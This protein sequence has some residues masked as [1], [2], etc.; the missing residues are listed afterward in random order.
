MER[1]TLKLRTGDEMPLAGF[2]TWKIPND[3]C[4]E[5]VYQALKSGYKLLD[6][7]CD[8]GNEEKVGEGI[9]R[10]TDEG[11]VNRKDLWVTSKLWNTYHRREHVKQACL[12][13]LKD[14]QLDYLDLYLIHF[15]ISLKY[16]DPEVRYPPEWFFDP[17]A[18]KPRM[19]EDPVPIIETWRAMEE[20]MAEGL[21]KNIG[22]CNFNTSLLRDLLAAAKVKPSV[23]Q[24][25]LHPYLTQK[26]LIQ[27]CKLNEIQ[28]TTFSS[29]GGA[30][31][32]E[33][34][35]ANEDESLLNNEKVKEIATTH[36]KTAGQVLLRW[37]VQ[38]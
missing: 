28:M 32:V 31:Y 14:L 18:N 22:I 27:F 9:K 6:C 35:M 15:P 19:I 4:S 25:E 30:S 7:A 11:L 16:V 1:T 36:K 10:A 8:Y 23:L 3:S 20:L 38:Q 26:E 17:K 21:V 34:T 2:G 5:I 33:L 13:T 37:A 29:F 12:R 24:V